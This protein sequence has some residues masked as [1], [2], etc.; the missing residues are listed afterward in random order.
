MHC[1]GPDGQEEEKSTFSVSLTDEV[2][3]QILRE[4]LDICDKRLIKHAIQSQLLKDDSSEI[5]LLLMPV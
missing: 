1:Q 2:V 4:R 5:L 3:E